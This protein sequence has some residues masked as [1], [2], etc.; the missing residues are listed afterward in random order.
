M[1]VQG[2]VKCGCNERPESLLGYCQDDF[3]CPRCGVQVTCLTYSGRADKSKPVYVYPRELRGYDHPQFTFGLGIEYADHERRQLTGC[4]N[5]DVEQSKGDTNRYFRTN[6]E[7]ATSSTKSSKCIVR[8]VPD[9]DGIKLPEKGVEY[10]LRRLT[11]DFPETHLQLLVAQRPAVRI[12]LTGRGI[13]PGPEETV[14]HL[15]D[16]TTLDVSLKIYAEHGPLVVAS[17]L[18]SIDCLPDCQDDREGQA[19]LTGAVQFQLDKNVPEGLEIVPGDPWSTTAKLNS[20]AMQEN[21]RIK[22]I[23][24]LSLLTTR[25]ESG[26]P[27]IDLVRIDKGQIEI[28]PNPVTISEMYFGELR[29]NSYNNRLENPD[30]RNDQNPIIRRVF[31]RN[32]DTSTNAVRLAPIDP[33]PIEPWL[34]VCWATDTRSD[35]IRPGRDR[36]VDLNPGQQAEVSIRVDLRK[37]TAS[38]VVYE[39][40]LSASV[41]IRVDSEETGDDLNIRINRVVPRIRCPQPLCVDFGNTSSFAAIRR[42]S[43]AD[44]AATVLREDVVPVH[45][46]WEPETFPTVMFFRDAPENPFD[47]DYEIGDLAVMEFELHKDSQAGLVSDLKRWI[48][49]SEHAKIIVDSHG[50]DQRYL[51]TDL[52]QLYLKR[53]VERAESILRQYTIGEICVSHPS[54]Y[55]LQRREALNAIVDSL[56]ERVTRDR[57]AEGQSSIPLRRVEQDVDEA[58]AVAVGSV[59][60][61]D[62]AGQLVPKILTSGKRSF[63]VACLDLGGGSLDTALIRFHQLSEN[64]RFP[65]YKTEYLGIGGHQDFG[66]DNVTRACV[67][68]LLTRIRGCLKK[69]GLSSEDVDETLN[70]IPAPREKD[71]TDRRRQNN[72]DVMWRVA[73]EIKKHECR[74]TE[75]DTPQLKSRL[76]TWLA[77]DLITVLTGLNSAEHPGGQISDA[78][79][80]FVE[81][82]QFRIDLADLYRHKIEV[83]L[84]DWN[85][86]YSIDSP[87]CDAVNELQTFASRNQADVDLVVLGGAGCRLPLVSEVI[88]GQFSNAYLVSQPERTKFRVAYGLVRFLG[89][90]GIHDFSRS[91]DYTIS[92]FHIGDYGGQAFVGKCVPNCALVN[93]PGTWYPVCDPDDESL[94][95]SIAELGVQPERV[96]VYRVEHGQSVQHGWFDLSA[97]ADDPD[98]GPGLPITIEQ[99]RDSRAPLDGESKKITCRVR[100]VGSEYDMELS[101]VQKGGTLGTWK[102][103]GTP[104]RVSSIIK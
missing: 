104:D 82:D 13:E 71:T 76:A 61:P 59:F 1:P 17:A 84:T 94:S 38:D 91:S 5:V 8:L 79:K 99:I 26:D 12:E 101:L 63:V 62:V 15:T 77:N 74:G 2:Q 57:E 33:R 22:L 4:P 96:R 21:D 19:R 48:N 93:A 18:E 35:S 43:D 80:E 88:Q 102:L 36:H 32:P 83:D 28:D 68:I 75:S 25:L 9:A 7:L 53:I 47:A 67:E 29:S 78:L 87:I 27:S 81:T 42:P 70:W 98:G 54:R 95:L 60:E 11:G 56:C 24:P 20:S 34:T 90:V 55:S 45:D 6:L 72:Y 66:G 46:L 44:P 52:I 40:G 73:E 49:S 30:R 50:Q 97:P 41:P 58:N 39:K 23:F 16:S 31:V 69:A 103:V 100:L 92:E 37:P 3:F 65:N 10:R 64:P 86:K 14:L 51:V 89:A 85:S